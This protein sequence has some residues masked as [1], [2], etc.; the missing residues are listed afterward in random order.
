MSKFIAVTIGDINGIGIDIYLKLLKENKFQN[1]VLFSNINLIKKYIKKN[2]Y[3]IEIN[4]VN[5]DKN[6]ILIKKNCLNIYTYNCNTHIYNTIKSIDLS[7]KECLKKR[8]KGMVTLPIRKDLINKIYPNF[9]GH[10]EHLQKFENIK[11]S[12]MIFYHKK[13]IIS[14]LTTHIKLNSVSKFIQKKDFLL[15]QIINLNSSLVR[16]FNIKDPKIIIAGINPHAGE[17][18]KIGREEINIIKPIINKLIKLN[19]NIKGPFS[20]DTMLI[21]KNLK[22]FNC[23]VFIYHDQALI[24]FKYISKFQGVNFTGNLSVIRTSPDHGTAYDLKGKKNISS[25]SLVNSFKLID[26]I[27]ENRKKNGKSKKIIKSKFFNR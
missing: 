14:S 4:V 24:P 1:T 15:N 25:D 2:K 13:I 21:N 8:F 16:D 18:G 20:A 7:Y 12:N 9:I 27:Y 22:M 3:K 19:I 5:K 10:T 6:I 26:K 23:F 17:N 11:Y